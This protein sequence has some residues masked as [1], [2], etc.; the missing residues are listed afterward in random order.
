MNA[1][2]NE[3]TDLQKKSTAGVTL[4]ELIL[5]VTILLIVFVPITSMF[6]TSSTEGARARKLTIATF[7]A[8]QKIEE[9]VGLNWAELIGLDWDEKNINT[10]T[11]EV[12]SNPALSRLNVND[13]NFFVDIEVSE[14]S[15]HSVG[16]MDL[17]LLITVKVT[18]KDYDGTT[19]LISQENILNVVDGGVA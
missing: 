1:V 3:V 9:L 16:D 17:P 12:L 14:R 19:V 5:A 15:A 2:I 13:E 7:I 6:V 10:T 11:A 18:I 8:Q 4:L